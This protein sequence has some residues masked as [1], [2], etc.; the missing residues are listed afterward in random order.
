MGQNDFYDKHYFFPQSVGSS[1]TDSC[2][3]CDKMMRHLLDLN[4][5]YQNMLTTLP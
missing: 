5:A 3:L 1:R 4:I 2:T